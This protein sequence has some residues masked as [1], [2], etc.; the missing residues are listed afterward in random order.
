MLKKDGS[1][2]FPQHASLLAGPRVKRR[3]DPPFLYG[4]KP[5][6]PIKINWFFAAVARRTGNGF[7]FDNT[8]IMLYD[9]FKIE[10]FVSLSLRLLH[11][12]VAYVSLS[13][14]AEKAVNLF[15]SNAH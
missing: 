1:S 15:S 13:P 6:N 2:I 7:L 9:A 4:T 11:D 8:C 14:M 12:P 10:F 5:C 3:R